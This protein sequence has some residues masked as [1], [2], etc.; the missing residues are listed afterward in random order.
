MPSE[1]AQVW[2]AN[3][4]IN[5]ALL[6][7]VP[8]KALA[9]KYAERTRTVAAQFAH[10]HN[11]RIYHLERRGPAFL[12]NLEGFARGAQPGKTQLRKALNAS[13]KAVADLLDECEAAGRVKSWKGPPAS[14]LGYFVAHEAHHRALAVVSLRLSGTKLPKDVLYGIW[15]SWRK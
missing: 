7:A 12:G 15:Y 6:D 5:L 10:I 3:N 11:V 4:R 8:A 1:L 13:A 9:D 14:Y 2:T